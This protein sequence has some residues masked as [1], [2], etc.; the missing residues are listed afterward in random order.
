MTI[1]TISRGSFS[2]GKEIAEEVAGELGYECVARRVLLEAS[3]VY[4]IPEVKLARAIHDAPSVLD[5]VGGGKE[6][7]VAYI[8]AALADRVKEG[9][10]VYHGLAGHFLLRDI[11]HVLKVRVN[12]ALDYRVRMVMERD[13]VPREEA[14]RVLHRDDAARINWS[15][16]IWGF[17]QRDSSLYDLVVNID[18]ISVKDAVKV[19][20]MLART[21]QFKATAESR[22]IMADLALATAVRCR[23][24]GPK[25]DIL[26]TARDGIVEVR[27][28]AYP[29]YGDTLRR[30]MESLV[31][32]VEGVSEVRVLLE[33]APR[34]NE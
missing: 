31:M 16:R 19:I 11:P 13:G 4:D 18:R 5:R 28:G 23:L 2:R 33:G 27:T 12:A 3:R 21:D 25:P 1:I 22:R 20:C 6:R 24:I 29:I 14:L 26:V 8:Q 17:N 34:F 7:Y 15:R 9:G 32:S 30:E 10:V